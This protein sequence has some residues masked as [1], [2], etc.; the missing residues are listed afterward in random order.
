M[1]DSI[2][3]LKCKGCIHVTHLQCAIKVGFVGFNS[4]RKLDGEYWCQSCDVKVNMYY[5]II[6]SG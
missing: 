3:W 1:V 5:L 2:F 6:L 4:I